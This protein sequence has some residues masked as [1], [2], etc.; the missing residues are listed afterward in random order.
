M[1]ILVYKMVLFWLFFGGDVAEDSYTEGA[2]DREVGEGDRQTLF[3]LLPA[4]T[5]LYSLLSIR[6]YFT[7]HKT[8]SF[9]ASFWNLQMPFS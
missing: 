9:H 8:F 6:Q 3:S 2:W 4:H 7:L 5:V 1:N